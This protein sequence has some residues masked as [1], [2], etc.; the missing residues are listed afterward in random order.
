M[1]DESLKE[2]RDK[3]DKTVDVMSKEFS[4]VRTGRANAG[5]LD[6]IKVSY[7][8]GEVPL[9]QIASVSVVEGRS[10]EIKPYDS[11]ALAEIEKAI[12]QANLG[13]TPQNDGKL[14][15]LSFP[16]LTEERRKELAKSVKK[17]AEDAK[18]S[19]RNIRRDANDKVK[20]AAK[21]KTVSEDQAKDAETQI[22]KHTDAVIKKVDDMAGKKEH[23]VLTL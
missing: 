15:R 23:E 7:Y 1:L 4:N 19:L 16:P 2:M 3:M 5:L 8:G 9:Q 12:F 14:V 10:L 11:S 13:L 20:A 22:Q 17:L 6:G 18:V 21:A